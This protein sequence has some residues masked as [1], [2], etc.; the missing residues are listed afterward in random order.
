MESK[1]PIV[2]VIEDELSLTKIYQQ[3]L[4]EHYSVHIAKTGTEGIQKAIDLKPSLILL[5]IILPGEDDGFNVLT[6]LKKDP[7]TSSIPIFVAT[8]LSQEWKDQAMELGAD[9]Y[10]TKTDISL[11]KIIEMINKYLNKLTKF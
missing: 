9:E 4:Q 1:K 11:S 7:K 3:K 5:D 10:L 2:L 6:K 8:N